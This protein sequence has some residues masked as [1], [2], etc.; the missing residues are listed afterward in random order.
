MPMSVNEC[1]VTPGDVVPV[2]EAEPEAPPAVDLPPRDLAVAEPPS[3]LRIIGVNMAGGQFGLSKDG[4][5]ENKCVAV[6]S[7]I[8]ECDPRKFLNASH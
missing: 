6:V 3:Q 2:P 4:N 7:V 1:D 5:P 8:H